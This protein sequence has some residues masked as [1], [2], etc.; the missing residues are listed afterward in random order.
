[1]VSKL[2]D[3][4]GFGVGVSCKAIIGPCVII[5]D[6]KDDVRSGWLGAIGCFDPLPHDQPERG[7]K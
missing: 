3:V 6:D 2:V 5:A 1:M 4:W 7:E